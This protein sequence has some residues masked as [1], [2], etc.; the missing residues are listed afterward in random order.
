MNIN[1]DMALIAAKRDLDNR[2][3]YVKKYE[4]DESTAEVV[5]RTVLGINPTEE[6]KAFA[7]TVK[8]HFLSDTSASDFS[9]NVRSILRGTTV[10]KKNLGFVVCLPSVYI[11]NI[12]REEQK[13]ANQAKWDK[14]AQE[15][16]YVAAVGAKVDMALVLS[17]VYAYDGI[18]GTTYIHSFMDSNNRVL[19]WKTSKDLSD[20]APVGSTFNIKGTVKEH[21]DYRNVKQTVLTRCKAS[22]IQSVEQA[23]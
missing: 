22:V 3:K 13:K 1:I 8:A 23:A 2:G 20:V 9:M 16:D 14:M 6:E 4:N 15:S 18:F 21:S 12:E 17:N 10:T 7:D 11:R 19:V 5:L